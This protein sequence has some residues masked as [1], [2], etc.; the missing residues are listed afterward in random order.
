MNS[1]TLSRIIIFIL[2]LFFPYQGYANCWTYSE[3]FFGI[4]AKLLYSIA[5]VESGLKPEAVGKNNNGS[6]DLGLMQINSSHIP[7]L[8]KIGVDDAMLTSDPCVSILVGA[9]ILSD[10]MKIYGYSWEAVGAYNSGTGK[11]RHEMRM[12]YAKKVWDVY[13]KGNQPF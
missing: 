11:N 7:R 5:Q 12:K 9:S 13:R 6:Y 10:M 3:Q 2:N 1:V 4:E 8:R